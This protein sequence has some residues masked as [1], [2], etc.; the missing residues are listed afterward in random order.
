MSSSYVQRFLLED[1]DIRGAVVRLDDA[2]QAMT[3]RRAYPQQVSRLLGEMSA[4]AAIIAGN[5]KQ[6]GRLGFQLS[7]SGP[8]QALIID[9]TQNLELR[10][11]ARFAEATAPD[12][13]GFA[14]MIGSEGRLL[15]TLDTPLNE[16][17]YQSFVPLAGASIAAVFEHYLAQSEQQPAR[18]F[19]AADERRAAGLFLQKLPQADAR[20]ADGWT[21][22]AHLASTV[23]PAELLDLAPA[24]LLGRLF[25]EEDKRLFEPRQ[26]SHRCPKDWEKVRHMVRQLGRAELEAILAEHGEVVVHD[27]ICN[28]EYRFDAAAIAELLSAPAEQPTLH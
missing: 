16:L 20:D 23:Q 13:T 7:G 1:L 18:L 28:H 21:R 6:P 5:L 10:G 22:I 24:E 17:P 11:M 19:L 2:W 9:C 12:G 3:A 25:A 8:L 27:D 14:E 15:L 4:V 26:V